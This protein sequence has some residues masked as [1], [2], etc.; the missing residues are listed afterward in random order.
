MK[1]HHFYHVYADG[2]CEQPIREHIKA[3]KEYGLHDAL[4]TFAIGIVGQPHKRQEVINCL[5]TLD[6]R[7]TI[8]A[9]ANEGWEQVTMIPMWQFS[10]TNDGLML[11][12]HTKGSSN[13]SE[14]NERWRRSMT[15]HCVCQ[16]K[17]AIEKLQNHRSYSCHW[18]QP[19]VSMPEHR[20]G[21]FM[22]AGTFFWTHCSLMRTWM[23]PPL[24][25]RF[26]AEGW[27][28]YKYAEEPWPVWDCTPYFPNTD[29]FMDE[30]LG[31]PEYNP[32]QR[33]ISIAPQPT[34]NVL[35]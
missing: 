21:N 17:F 29:S 10:Q 33:G 35:P 1:L 6:I 32:Q 9:E 18:I 11:Y 19:L 7:Y 24:N 30:W 12:A 13:V 20:Q 14:V 28:G 5:N 25:H 34:I 2:Q 4:T 23:S 15:W 31:N 22:A 3:L 26:E 27:I 16:W 8:C